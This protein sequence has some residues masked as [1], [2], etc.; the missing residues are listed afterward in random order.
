MLPSIFPLLMVSNIF[1]F[2]VIRQPSHALTTT[3]YSGRMNAVNLRVV[4]IFRNQSQ[5]AVDALEER[6]NNILTDIKF[7]GMNVLILEWR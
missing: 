5:T 2:L 6:M 1:P 4:L 3:L 7:A